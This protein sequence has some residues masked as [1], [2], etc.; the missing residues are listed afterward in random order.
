MGRLSPVV[1]NYDNAATLT[2]VHCIQHTASI[3]NVLVDER[4]HKCPMALYD[5]GV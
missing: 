2:V 1:T 3:M 4:D 5:E